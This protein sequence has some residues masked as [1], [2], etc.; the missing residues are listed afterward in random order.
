MVKKIGIIAG[1]CILIMAF[2]SC[3]L[4][5]G[6]EFWHDADEE[7]A[8]LKTEV[9]G[10]FSFLGDA[11]N[12]V[13]PDE[14]V[15]NFRT[16][17]EEFDAKYG[18]QVKDAFNDFKKEMEDKIATNLE[19]LTDL[20]VNKD[21]LIFL[22]GGINNAGAIVMT[23]LNPYGST[24][25][26][27]HGAILDLDK[28]VDSESQCFQTA[29][30]SG[31]TYE[32][33]SDWQQKVNVAVLYPDA[34][35]IPSQ[36]EFDT[37]LSKAQTTVDTY[38]NG[39]NTTTYGFFKDVANVFDVVAKDLSD[40]DYYWYCS[41]IVWNV[42]NQ[43]E[44]EYE[45]AN[46]GVDVDFD[47]DSDSDTLDWSASGLY[48]IIKSYYYTRYWDLTVANTK[49]QEYI[50]G[51]DTEV[52]VKKILVLPEEIYASPLLTKEYEKIRVAY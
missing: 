50:N 11:I 19:P 25:S 46:P 7:L 24:G 3:D 41:K 43:L 27:A 20:P 33:F 31:A 42:Y 4:I 28:Y 16:Q 37:A 9:E 5:Q 10:V 48:Q 8:S 13:N 47:I 32:T 39:T 36:T 30:A 15:D 35:K 52:G 40:D 26:Y 49:I 1:F 29:L 2:V 45:T 18:S 22:S 12:S 38:C 51:S 44:K 23:F 14:I 34:S 21:G 6:L 17:L